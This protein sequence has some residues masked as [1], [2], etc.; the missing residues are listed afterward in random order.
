M[1][2]CY[3]NFTEVNM[4]RVKGIY[5]GAKVILL[6]PLTLPPD[7]AVEVLVPEVGEKPEQRYWQRLV[8]LGLVKEIRER[9]ATYNTFLPVPIQGGSIA[10]DIIAERR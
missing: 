9:Q 7:T 10:Q 2:L 3:N 8:E 6:E 5:D 1:G 4:L